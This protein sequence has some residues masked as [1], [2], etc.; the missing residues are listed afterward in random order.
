MAMSE[1]FFGKLPGLAGE[2][3]KFARNIGEARLW[4]GVHWRSD[5]DAGRL[6]GNAVGKLIKDQLKKTG[7]YALLD[8]ELAVPDFNQQKTEAAGFAANCGKKPV[9]FCGGLP[10]PDKNNKL[11]IQNTKLS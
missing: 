4:G 1:C 5:D 2:F 7:I 3:N 6:I 10:K 8:A 9:D 11:F